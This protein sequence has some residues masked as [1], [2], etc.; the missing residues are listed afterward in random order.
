MSERA[1]SLLAIAVIGVLSA[2][3][4]V[5]V[6]TAPAPEANRSEAIGSLIKCPVCGGESIADSPAGLAQDMMG[7]VEELVAQGFSDEQV[8]D[9]ILA[10][11]GGAQLL[12]PPR[13]GITLL[14]WLSP[15][16]GLA[17]GWWLVAS[18]RRPRARERRQTGDPAGR[19]EE[20]PT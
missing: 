18:R 6:T 2:F 16:V 13:S 1:R 3:L 20:T 17:A 10:S 9:E 7:Q 4:V 11:Y 19:L 15:L 5:A 12:D 8:V 14:L